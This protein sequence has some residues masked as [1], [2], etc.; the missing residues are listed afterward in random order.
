MDIEEITFYAFRARVA[1]ESAKT[2]A[3]E[4]LNSTQARRI[5]CDKTLRKSEWID[6]GDNSCL[7]FS[8]FH[9]RGYYILFNMLRAQIWFILAMYPG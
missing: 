4:E 3:G 9:F 2:Y 7:E 1:E 8:Y 6:R 5:A